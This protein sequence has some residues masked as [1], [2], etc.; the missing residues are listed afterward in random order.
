MIQYALITGIT[1]Q[2]GSYLSE[3]LLNR[4]YKVYG[5]IRRSSNFNT[6]RIEHIFNQLNLFYG[7]MTDAACLINV[8]MKIKHKMNVDDTIFVFH[9]GAQSHVKV[10]FELPIY[11][12]Q[13]NAIGTLN[14]L[15][16]IRICGLEK[17]CRMY[18]AATSELYGKVRE[19][20]QT[21]KTIFYPRSP[22]GVSK[23]YTYW[24]CKNYRESY[25]MFICNGILFNHCSTR[26]G[27]TFVTRKITCGL[28]KILKGEIDYI[29]LGNVNAKR[30]WGW[31]ED[32]CEAM[33]IILE[34]NIP[35]D[36][37][38]STGKAHSVREFIVKAF[39]HKGYTIKWKGNGL[40]E[41]GYDEITG[42]VLIKIDKKYFRPAEVDLLVGDCSKMKNLGWKP[43][44]DFDKIVKT[45]V[46]FDCQSIE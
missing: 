18:N 17:Q 35:D 24:I 9:L 25:N 37:V 41:V 12:T 15:E 26:R 3:L 42:K 4:G 16:A 7:D 39:S 40:D 33:I 32:Y 34:H 27:K 11:T 13:T 20:P 23:L 1:G 38:V 43:K 22:Y 2:D 31:A 21:E 44:Y 5:I 45:M 8:L 36:Y 30:D 28:A 6:Q 19:V 29:T 10:S 14:L 46:D